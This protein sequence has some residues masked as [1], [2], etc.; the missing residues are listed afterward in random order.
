[1]PRLAETVADE[2]CNLAARDAAI[3]IVDGDLG[4]SYGLLKH[5]A[6]LQNQFI[7][8]GIAEQTMIGVAAG[9]AA[10]GVRPFV[11]SFAAFLCCRAYDQ[12]RVCVSQT[13]LPVV[14]VGSHAGGCGGPN[15][16]SH[17][18]LNDIA[19]ISS[20]PGISIWAPTDPV[21]AQF[22]VLSVAAAEGPAY[23]RAPR[24][25]QGSLPGSASIVRRFGDSSRAVMLSTGLASRW[26]LE[27]QHLLRQQGLE[28]AVIHVLRIAPFPTDELR[29]ALGDATQIVVID[30]HYDAGGLADFTRRNFPNLIVTSL[31]WPSNW[32]G[33]SGE[34]YDLRVAHSLDSTALAAVCARV[35]EEALAHD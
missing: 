25:D 18:I 2:V 1:M 19:M 9:L 35:L 22:A 32:Q 28:M 12:I 4:D 34:T 23:I 10:C 16:K 29:V 33:E 21:D 7:Q 6:R 14:I 5:A 31:A 3:W 20:L 24:D 8:A 30:D 17:I 15:G 27:A 13:E 26:A 11:F